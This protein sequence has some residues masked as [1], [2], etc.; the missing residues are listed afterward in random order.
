MYVNKL[1]SVTV[2]LIISLA[3]AQ[4]NDVFISYAHVD[5]EFATKI[6]EY[7]ELHS[8]KW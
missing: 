6:K 5:L 8:I 2:F 4:K 7:L 3:L 1:I